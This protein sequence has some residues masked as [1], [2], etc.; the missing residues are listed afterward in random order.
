MIIIDTSIGHSSIE[1]VFYQFWWQDIT[2]SYQ[3]NYS[4]AKCFNLKSMPQVFLDLE[5][6]QNSFCLKLHIC[7]RF[8]NSHTYYSDYLL[9]INWGGLSPTQLKYAQNTL[10]T[11]IKEIGPFFIADG[12]LIKQYRAMMI[13]CTNCASVGLFRNFGCVFKL[14]VQRNASKSILLYIGT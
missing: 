6:T 5:T 11:S 8:Y 3:K 13:S 9:Y 2:R 10:E 14:I 1:R 4:I 7:L 12:V